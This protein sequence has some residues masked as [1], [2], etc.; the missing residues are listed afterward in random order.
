MGIGFA[1]AEEGTWWCR[2]GDPGEALA[3]A[4]AKCAAEGPGLDGCVPT[5]WCA[6]ARWT[7]LM[8]V[9]LADFHSTQVLCGITSREALE[10]ALAALCNASLYASSCDLFLVIDPDGGEMPVDGVGFPGGGA[11]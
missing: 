8:T 11:E 4:I 5:Q 10:A 1:Q 6:P 7:G 3:C 2:D 9:W